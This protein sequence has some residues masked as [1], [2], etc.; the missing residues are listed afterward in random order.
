MSQ[1]TGEPVR[2]PFKYT[3]DFIIDEG[4]TLCGY[5]P[6]AA[7]IREKDG[8]FLLM[9]ARPG[10]DNLRDDDLRRISSSPMA[11]GTALA[12]S[13]L[14]E[15]EATEAET[16]ERWVFAPGD[17]LVVNCSVQGI[18]GLRRNPG[19]F[20]LRG[21]HC[22]EL[23]GGRRHSRHLYECVVAPGSPLVGRTVESLL[24]L[25][26]HTPVRSFEDRPFREVSLAERALERIPDFME[27]H[28]GYPLAGWRRSDGNGS[29]PLSLSSDHLA[30][31]DVLLIDAFD[32][33]PGLLSTTTNFTVT[34]MVS[35]SRAP[36]HGR[37][38]DQCRG[39]WAI[40]ALLGAII[41]TDLSTIF[42]GI[43]FPLVLGTLVAV[44]TLCICRAV[45]LHQVTQWLSWPLLL[46]FGAGEGISG[47][48]RNTG[49]ACQSARLIKLLRECA[50]AQFGEGLGNC[51]EKSVLAILA[52]VFAN[53]LSNAP[54]GLIL[55]PLAMESA[56]L[57]GSK[58]RSTC[59]LV[60][61]CCNLVLSTPFGTGANNS[62][63][64][65]AGFTP[66]TW[67]K[68]G[69]PAQALATIVIVWWSVTFEQI[70]APAPSHQVTAL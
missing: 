23:L 56:D 4:S 15:A 8:I 40:V 32:Q 37:S 10:L 21:L 38:R 6:K 46:M 44:V 61:I 55:A 34:A 13:H 49:V 45:L 48:I 25:S 43:R 69:L 9:I 11:F 62:V 54:A 36:R 28:M 57:G 22:L 64:R 65:I 66:A 50:C 27:Q 16:M 14:W 51:V 42:G 39:I 60:V 47:A 63:S 33:F 20:A 68:F 58:G 26:D 59:I 67:L 70:S 3:L 41:V 31:G 7:G 1:T 2:L 19:V 5:T 30:V 53:T 18:I 35:N 12:G 17:V 52:Q 24:G 29:M